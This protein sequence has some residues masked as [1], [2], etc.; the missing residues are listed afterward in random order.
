[1]PTYLEDMS[2]FL[3]DNEDCA[4]AFPWSEEIEENTYK[5]VRYFKRSIPDSVEDSL[6]DDFILQRYNVRE[7]ILYAS[8]ML[9]SSVLL[10]MYPNRHIYEGLSGQNPQLILPILYNYKCGYVKKILYKAIARKNSDSRLENKQDFINRT[11]SWENIYCNVI[12]SIPNM[13]EYEK[14]YYFASI[15]NFWEIERNKLLQSRKKRNSFFSITKEYNGQKKHKVITIL[16]I[17]M[18]FRA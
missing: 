7:R 12:K 4:I 6:F 9:R 14:A 8:F 15:K 11:Y 13:P 10:S 16:G 2:K 3:D 18:K 5:H 1:M 17:K